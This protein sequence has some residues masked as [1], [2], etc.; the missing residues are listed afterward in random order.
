MWVFFLSIYSGCGASTGQTLAQAP[1]S[2]QASASI[3]YISPG[4]IAST[5]HS[6]SQAPHA[7][8]VS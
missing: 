8:H 2:I 3:T 6:G 4:D 1:Q 5:G 7:I